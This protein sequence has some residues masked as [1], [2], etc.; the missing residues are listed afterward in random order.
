MICEDCEDAEAPVTWLDPWGRPYA[1]LC[2]ECAE[3]RIDRYEP[4]TFD[5]AL[6]A[7]CDVQERDRQAYRLKRG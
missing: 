6:G 3:R 4:P 7:R 5:E 2:A 1:H